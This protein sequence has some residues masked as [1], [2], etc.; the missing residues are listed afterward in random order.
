MSGNLGFLLEVIVAGLLVVTIAYCAL[1]DARLKRLRQD[2]T[3]MRK[4]VTD[5]SGATERAE[6]AIEALRHSLTECDRTLAERL[7]V[8]ERYAADLEGQIK[9]GDAVLAR[10]SKIVTSTRAAVES[11]VSAPAMS[12]V[13]STIAAAE[14]LA[15]RAKPKDNA[16]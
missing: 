11:A 9:S 5:L 4:I 3:A 7:R 16:A 1:L 10:I 13:A 14:A 12:R 6:R 2:E 15:Q 8:A